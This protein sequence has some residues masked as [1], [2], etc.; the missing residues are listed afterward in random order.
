MA[1]TTQEQE[2]KNTLRNKELSYNQLSQLWIYL[3]V[4]KI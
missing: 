3:Q 4:T 1:A 2:P